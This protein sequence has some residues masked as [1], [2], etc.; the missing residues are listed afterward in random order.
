MDYSFI[1]QVTKS[2]VTE[3]VRRVWIGG[4]S[5]VALLLAAAAVLH[6]Y[7]EELRSS[8]VNETKIQETIA[9]QTAQ[10]QQQQ[11]Q[12]ELKQGLRQRSSAEDQLLADQLYDLL[13]LVPDDSTLSRFD[14]D[15]TSLLYEGV[16]NDFVALREGL[17]RALSGRYRLMDA[18]Q[19]AE[20][21]RTH[22]ILRFSAKGEVQ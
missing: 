11:A 6:L 9:L 7:N 17:Q 22:F 20:E 16:C 14:Y 18:S 15:G 1:D 5:L 2:P 19:S 21:G 4:A 12:F 8:V 13:A 10:L 3:A